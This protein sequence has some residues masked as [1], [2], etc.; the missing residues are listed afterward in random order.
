[1]VDDETR[2]QIEAAV[3]QWF[4]PHTGDADDSDFDRLCDEY[5]GNPEL[6]E[7]TAREC[8]Q[9]SAA[10]IGLRPRD[11]EGVP[12]VDPEGDRRA[13]AWCRVAERVWELLPELK[14]SE[15]PL[16]RIAVS[17]LVSRVRQELVPYGN[18]S[19]SFSGLRNLFTQVSPDERERR[20]SFVVAAMED[21]LKSTSDQDRERDLEPWAAALYVLAVELAVAGDLSRASKYRRDPHLIEFEAYPTGE[22]AMHASSLLHAERIATNE[23]FELSRMLEHSVR[24]SAVLKQGIE[25][26][27]AEE[28]T[29]SFLESYPV[30]KVLC[31]ALAL[32]GSKASQYD[33]IWS[34]SLVCVLGEATRRMRETGTESPDVRDIAQYLLSPEGYDAARIPDTRHMKHLM[35][36]V[37]DHCKLKDLAYD[38]LNRT[39]ETHETAAISLL[40]ALSLLTEY[41]PHAADPTRRL[42]PLPF[43]LATVLFPIGDTEDDQRISPANAAMDAEFN[44]PEVRTLLRQ[45]LRS[46]VSPLWETGNRN[47]C[48]DLTKTPDFYRDLAI[49]AALYMHLLDVDDKSL[50]NELGT[51]R[52]R[53]QAAARFAVQGLTVATRENTAEESDSVATQAMMICAYYGSVLLIISGEGARA[54]SSILHAWRIQEEPG[55]TQDLE[56]PKHWGALDKDS[57]A[58]AVAWIAYHT[59]RGHYE[60]TRDSDL[61]HE[62][63]LYCLKRF[64]KARKPREIPPEA[65]EGWDATRNEPSPLWRA[66]YVRALRELDGNPDGRVFRTLEAVSNRDASPDVRTEADQA[67]EEIGGIQGSYSKKSHR[68]AMLHAWLEL[69]RA[70]MEQLNQ[71]IDEKSYEMLREREAREK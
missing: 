16:V 69:R 47:E 28:G 37:D 65:G 25:L 48:I 21:D 23:L 68:K 4:H 14:E 55:L 46:V 45:S 70:H 17:A 54:V 41:E 31:C 66:A 24:Q 52:Q 11:P 35:Y 63:V 34:E 44:T 60:H 40:V 6:R 61:R 43:P 32:A 3:W 26:L 2:K 9:H 38:W 64:D 42:S 15:Q 10:C 71:P 8:R 59:F 36:F 56:G 53:V 12:G 5:L 39:Q 13:R 18:R 58:A 49:L 7:V 57:T 1:M 33:S 22:G 27:L 67:L 62:F 30:A 20:I 50:L 51:M 29:N 19:P